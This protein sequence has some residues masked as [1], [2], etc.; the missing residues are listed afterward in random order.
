MRHYHH[1]T[2]EERYF[3]IHEIQAKVP[4]KIIAER[5]GVSRSTIYRELARNKDPDGIYRHDHADNRSIKR[6]KM[7]RKRTVLTPECQQEIIRH[8]KMDWSP[9]QITGRFRL[10]GKAVPSHQAIYNWIWADK[11]QKGT[12][13]QLLRRKHHYQHG[14]KTAANHLP[15]RRMIDERPAIV[16]QRSRIGDWEIDTIIS[17]KGDTTVL[18]T[19]VDRKS[20]FL[21]TKVSPSKKQ[22]VMQKK[23]CRMVE[24]N[25]VK[26]HTITSD[27][28]TEFADH[29][30]IAKKLQIDFFFARAH[31]P[32]ERGTNENTNGLLRQYIPK[33]TLLKLKQ[34]Q[35][36]IMEGVQRINNR[37]RKVLGFQTPKEVFFS[38]LERCT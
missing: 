11:K 8:L 34:S 5:L 19:L 2:R 13:Y 17:G 14:R 25:K 6:R 30:K 7:C 10:E 29:E 1:L 33:G 32:W 26:V 24:E 31:H 18:I 16:D 3:I 23:I 28:G 15:N 4:I 36:K 22:D 35:T 21:I 9:E 20:R 37:P 27:N 12:V 38:F